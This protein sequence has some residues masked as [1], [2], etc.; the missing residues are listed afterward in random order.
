MAIFDWVIIPSALKA[1][2]LIKIDIVK[3]MPAKQPTNHKF[4]FDTS[5]G[6]EQIFR[7]MP[8]IENKNIPKGFPISNPKTIPIELVLIKLHLNFLFPIFFR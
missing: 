3:P 6:N 4:I 7:P 1:S 2:K 8:S 5:F